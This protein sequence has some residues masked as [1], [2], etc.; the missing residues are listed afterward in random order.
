MVL[1]LLSEV[2]DAAQNSVSEVVRLVYHGALQP[3]LHTHSIVI[4]CRKR[5]ELRVMVSPCRGQ[6]LDLWQCGL[7]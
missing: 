3:W 4:A 5:R 1:P 6:K 7:P 2:S